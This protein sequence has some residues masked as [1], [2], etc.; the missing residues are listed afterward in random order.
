MSRLPK[1]GILADEMGLGKTVEILALILTHC[2]SSQLDN[3]IH[4]YFKENP[5]GNDIVPANIDSSNKSNE[6]PTSADKDMEVQPLSDKTLTSDDKSDV[7]SCL[8]G[9]IKCD[10]YVGLYVQCESCH[11]WQHVPCVDFNDEL[12]KDYVCIRCLLKEVYAMLFLLYCLHF[13]F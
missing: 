3:E 4:R 1:G 5:A 11:T 8:C 7:L 9:A 6:E 13:I 2:W 12:C 10:K